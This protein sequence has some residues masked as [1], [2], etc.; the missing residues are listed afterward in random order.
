MKLMKKYGMLALAIIFMFSVS[1]MAQDPAPHQEHHGEKKEL[2]R[3]EKLMI[4]PE[5]RAEKMT[6][7]L[8]LT[9]AQKAQVQAL[10]E[11]QDAKRHQ[12]MEKAEKMRAEMKAKFENERKMN[13]E[14][15]TKI[16]GQEKFQKLQAK[17]AER[18][19]KMKERRE[20]RKDH[21]TEN[22]QSK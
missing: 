6:K 17:R 13:D 18:L 14:E 10:F 7:G 21:S 9:N 4:S 20:T 22:A 16:I 11:K 19:E 5:K 3:G 15:L 2:K 8:E 12:E 1:V